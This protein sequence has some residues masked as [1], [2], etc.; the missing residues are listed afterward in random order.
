MADRQAL[1]IEIL[2]HQH[3]GLSVQLEAIMR[4]AHLTPLEEQTAR[5]LKKKK[6]D[7]KDRIV[8]LQRMIR[9]Y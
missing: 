2:E 8:A 3:R 9:G 5:E 6:L 1:N 4:H 7:A